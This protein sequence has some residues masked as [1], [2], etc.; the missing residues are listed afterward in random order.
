MR[1]NLVRKRKLGLENGEVF[2]DKSGFDIW[3]LF[4]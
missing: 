2:K 1:D 3:E 4:V